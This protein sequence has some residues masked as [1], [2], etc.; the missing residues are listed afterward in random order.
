MNAKA[1]AQL[2]TQVLMDEM[3]ARGWDVCVMS[4]SV[5]RKRMYR[6]LCMRRKKT[7][8]TWSYSTVYV[9]MVEAHSMAFNH[10]PLLSWN[11]W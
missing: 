4:L 11:K 3:I 6:V 2:R 5:D 10:R 7:Y 8:S 1:L 9:A